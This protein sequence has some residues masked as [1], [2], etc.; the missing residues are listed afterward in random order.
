MAIFRT[1]INQGVTNHSRIKMLIYFRLRPGALASKTQQ[2]KMDKRKI[3]I[4]T[5]IIDQFLETKELI[6]N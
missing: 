5:K 2:Q 4:T 6:E 1:F 3:K